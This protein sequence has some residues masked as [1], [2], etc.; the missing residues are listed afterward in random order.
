MKILLLFTFL[1]LLNSQLTI[2][3]DDVLQIP[4]NTQFSYPVLTIGGQGPF[5][6]L[7]DGLPNGIVLKSG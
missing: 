7:A 5:S 4:L 3:C 1:V 6:Y 2:V